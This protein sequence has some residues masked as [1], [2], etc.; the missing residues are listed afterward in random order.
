MTK[1]FT[2]NF[3]K[4]YNI[5]WKCG[6]NGSITCSRPIRV[7]NGALGYAV[8]EKRTTISLRKYSIIKFK[9][10]TNGLRKW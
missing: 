7:S 1:I 3:V 10:N 6:S 9:V 5:A 8:S 4:K 2:K